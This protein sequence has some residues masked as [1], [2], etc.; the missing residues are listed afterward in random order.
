MAPKGQQ[1]RIIKESDFKELV[2]QAHGTDK[3][4]HTY[5]EYLKKG[6][7]SCNSSPERRSLRKGYSDGYPLCGICLDGGRQKESEFIHRIKPLASGGQEYSR[8]N[9]IALCRDCHIEIH[10][11]G[12]AVSG[13]I[14]F[15]ISPE[16]IIWFDDTPDIF[17]TEVEKS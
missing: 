2:N 15:N 17:Q 10:D 12:G 8:Q 14:E 16:E 3:A 6:D 1:I 9:S 4:T 13:S 11:S 7:N 5:S